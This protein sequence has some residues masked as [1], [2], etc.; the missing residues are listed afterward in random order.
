MAEKTY[1]LAQLKEMRE[2]V[3]ALG[4][5][6]KHDSP[7]TTATAQ[8]LHGVF[9]GN[10][11]QQ[12][13]F[14]NPGVRPGMFDATPQPRSFSSRIPVLPNPVLNE[15]VEIITGV[16]AG[17]GNNVTGACAVGPNG[18]LFKTCQQLSVYGEM[19]MSTRI[20][21]ITKM[22][23]QLTRADLP[24]EVYNTAVNEM[25]LMPNVPGIDGTGRIQSRLRAA[26]Y[27]T[28]TELARNKGQAD[29]KGVAGT[30][31][32]TYRGVSIQWNGMDALIKTG[33]TD[34]INGVACPAADSIV[35]TFNV[36]IDGGT[37]SNGRNIVQ[38]VTDAYYASVD[39]GEQLGITDVQRIIV[40]RHDAF[41]ALVDVWSCVYAVSYCQSTAAGQPVTRDA[42][43]TADLRNGMYTGRYLLIDGVP[44]PVAFDDSIERLTV[45]N[46]YYLSDIYIPA[47]SWAGRPLL[48]GEYF[49]LNNAD[50]SEFANFVGGDGMDTMT[51][52]DGLWRVFKYV[53]GGCLT[54]DFYGKYRLM[55][56]APFLSARVDNLLY[57]SYAKTRDAVPGQSLYA[58]G[59]TTHRIAGTGGQ[60]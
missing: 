48:Y 6:E 41:R 11:N 45:G 10:S 50:A 36:A 7:S 33:Y 52:N 57:K 60:W 3:D 4:L 47:V 17:S 31:D 12:G 8:A 20:D 21:D 22:G 59:G 9:P 13:L 24:R 43:A 35:E 44:V 58:N 15:K 28:F 23:Q 51:L 38:A 37:D 14:S 55:L 46:N 16:T 5:G 18:G 40:M 34:A 56:D 25:A 19:H 1:T 32:N 53:T 42:T 49:P 26:F 2:L 39:R 54:Y 30:A 27:T 29:F